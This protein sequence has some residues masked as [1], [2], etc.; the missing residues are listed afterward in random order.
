M[1]KSKRNTQS[2]KARTNTVGGK[3]ATPRY[4]L[5]ASLV[6]FATQVQA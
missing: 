1:L 3:V 5:A 6:G 4:L 2:K